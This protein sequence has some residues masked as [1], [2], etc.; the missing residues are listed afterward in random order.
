MGNYKRIDAGQ[1]LDQAISARTWNAMVDLL[2]DRGSKGQGD[3]RGFSGP[4]SCSYI[5]VKN[6]TGATVGKNEVVVLSTPRFSPGDNLSAF[7]SHKVFNATLPT[8]TSRGSIGVML[9]RTA[10]NA[11]GYAAV[12]G[13]IPVKVE[14]VHAAH[15]R[16]DF[17]NTVAN[18]KSGFSGS[19][20]MLWKEAG[21]G[22]KWAIIRW[23][24]TDHAV[25]L[26]TANADILINTGGLISVY[27][28]GA[29]SGADETAWLNWMHGGQQVSSGK[30]VKAEWIKDQ[31][32]WIIT[33]AECED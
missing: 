10:N 28:D 9:E 23:P 22:V 13:I 8:T 15:D 14:I 16:A 20:E 29:D 3:G 32:K 21:T 18:L 25:I 12:S 2:E 1:P 6:T 31:R 19:A 4:D 26:G 5:P 11:I 33:G 27:R 17:T 24:I 30:Q 7:L